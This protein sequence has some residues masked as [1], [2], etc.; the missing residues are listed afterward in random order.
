[1]ASY[2]KTN[3]AVTIA[4][5]PFLDKTDGVTPEVA[6]TVANSKT[7]VIAETDDNNAPTLVLDNVAGSD[8][9]N[10]LAHITNDD[11]GY[12]SLK[13]T[14]ANLNRL[15][16]LKVFIGDAANHCPVFH[17]FIILPAN[18]Y[19]S[20]VLGTDLLDANASQVGGQTVSAAGAVTFPGTIASTTNITSA[21]GVAL[22]ASQHVIVDSGTVTTLTN[23]PAVTTDWLTAAGVKA[24]AVTKIQTGLATPTNI[25]AA[26][27]VSLA[28]DQAVNAT[29]WAGQVIPTPAVTG[30]PKVDLTYIL[31]TLLTETAGQIAAAFKKFFDKATPTGTI[32]SLPDAVAGATGGVAIV[33]SVMGKSPATL[34]AGDVSGNLP[35]DVIAISGDTTAADNAELMF[36]GTGY[37]GGTA[38]LKVI[39]ESLDTQAKADVNAEVVDALNTDTYAEPGQEAPGATVSL[40][41]KIGYLYK[42]AINKMT[43]TSTTMSLYNS[44]G[45]TVDQKATVSD[46]GTTFDRGEIGSGP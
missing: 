23:L 8:A 11:A 4:V 35:A 40:V 24:D 45:S 37:A 25:T 38:R 15:G 21:A 42:M 33:G 41:K 9:T 32:N 26:T 43:Q 20:L 36:D 46:N 30:V 12:Y 18:V 27:G 14:A 19:D 28:A 17:E 10:T 2:L 13:L 39:A 29:K 22:A 3:T 1:M 31:G 6:L 7:T 5:G 44:A 16:R 34:A